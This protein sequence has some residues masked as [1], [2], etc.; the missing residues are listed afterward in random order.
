MGDRET[1]KQFWLDRASDAINK[2]ATYLQQRATGAASIEL[3][4][5]QA[6]IDKFTRV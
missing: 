2:A 5:A 4:N 3:Q 6:A 1:E